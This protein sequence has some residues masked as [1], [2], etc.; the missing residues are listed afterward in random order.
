MLN[1][2]FKRTF[3]LMEQ[4]LETCR[5]TKILDAAEN[6]FANAGFDG[7]S[8]REIVLKAGVNLATVY[9]YFGSKEGLMDAVLARRFDPLRQEHLELIRQ[10]EEE[11]EGK[12]LAVD[13]IL[14]AMLYPPLRLAVTASTKSPAVMRLI[15]RIVS[16]PNTHTQKF[17]R[18]HYQDVKRTFFEAFRRTLPNL[19]LPDLL[20]RIE[21]IWGAIAF[22]L[23]NPANIKEKT[24]GMCDP[25]DTEMVQA[26]MISF[27]AGGLCAAATP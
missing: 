11:A 16:E 12:P 18:E 3:D 23:C 14:G 20:W 1:V 5:K 2:C 27:F 19:P 10:C 24:S 22:I 9:Y 6:A 8:L 13:K 21:F 17:L 7:A 4:L 26:Q 15:G 25:L